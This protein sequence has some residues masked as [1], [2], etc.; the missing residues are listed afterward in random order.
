MPKYSIVRCRQYHP[1]YVLEKDLTYEE[2][3]KK[4]NSTIRLDDKG[5]RIFDWVVEQEN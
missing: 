4:C 3:Q 5:E 1:N 2:A